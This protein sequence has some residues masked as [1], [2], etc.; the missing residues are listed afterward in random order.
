MGCNFYTKG[1]ACDRSSQ[2][3]ANEMRACL[4]RDSLTSQQANKE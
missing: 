1:E 3:Q 2:Q 4:A